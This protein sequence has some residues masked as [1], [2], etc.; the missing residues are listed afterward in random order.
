MSSCSFFFARPFRKYLLVCFTSFSA[1]T[2][3]SSSFRV[4]LMVVFSRSA[5]R[6][7][8]CS[9]VFPC[10][11]RAAAH[12]CYRSAYCA[13]GLS[14]RPASDFGIHKRLSSGTAHI[15]RSSTDVRRQVSIETV[16]AHPR[17]HLTW[18]PPFGTAADLPAFLSFSLPQRLVL[19]FV[20]RSAIPLIFVLLMVRR[21]ISCFF[22][23]IPPQLFFVYSLAHACPIQP[24]DNP[25]TDS[26]CSPT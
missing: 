26:L 11:A 10:L 3:R 4:S 17:E 6:G 22:F 19:P 2:R 15:R 5:K 21:V 13:H 18:V 24:H 14:C 25:D 8:A 12:S 1:H 9:S 7:C 20:R 16:F 23:L